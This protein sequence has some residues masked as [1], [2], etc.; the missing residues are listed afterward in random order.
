MGE[1][2]SQWH[3]VLDGSKFRI[4][5]G[6]YVVKNNADPEVNNLV[7]RQEEDQFFEREPWVRSLGAHKDRFGTLNLS[8]KL[9]K[10][11][12]AHIKTR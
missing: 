6:Y 3:D 5:H 8:Y 4:G 7:A 12:N 11:L 9:S 10:L 2:M 1:S